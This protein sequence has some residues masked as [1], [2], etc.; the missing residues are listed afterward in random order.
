[1]AIQREFNGN[2][3]GFIPQTG[4]IPGVL[5]SVKYDQIALNEETIY[6]A[7]KTF[8]FLTIETFTTISTMKIFYHDFIL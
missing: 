7:L 4:V 3:H 8:R 1:M 2:H 5:T 6:P